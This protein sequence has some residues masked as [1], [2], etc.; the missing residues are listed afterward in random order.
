M[1]HTAKEFKIP[2][3]FIL[4]GS[5]Y[6]IVFENELY[7][8]ED[9]FG[10]AEED[11]KLIRLQSRVPVPVIREVRDDNGVFKK[12]KT[13]FL[14]TDEIVVETFYHEISHIILDAI[15]ETKLSRDEKL[16]NMLGKAFLEI[17]LSSEYEEL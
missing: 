10:M 4:F 6:N 17:Y 9:C 8:K 1:S 5:K 16:V 7:E 13:S 2:T 14:I 3:S 15:G 11:I 12:V